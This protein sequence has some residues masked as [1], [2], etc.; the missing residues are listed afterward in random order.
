MEVIDDG[1][2]LLLIS[3][4]IE[5]VRDCLFDVFEPVDLIF[6]DTYDD[7]QVD[8][9]ATILSNAVLE[10]SD[11][12]IQLE[13]LQFQS[14]LLVNLFLNVL[15]HNGGHL[16]RLFLLL[17]HSASWLHSA[18]QTDDFLF[19]TLD[20]ILHGLKI[21]RRVLI[22]ACLFTLDQFGPSCEAQSRKSLLIKHSSWANI[23]N[24]I[25][26]RISPQ[27]ILE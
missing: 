3:E 19:Q 6:I 23:G 15:V 16:G 25:R 26:L 5:T 18:H 10:M 2:G 24:K 14:S 1:F 8:L 7:P 11:A 4:V 20:L 17:T 22:N 9:V 21:P 13:D 12:V 27:R